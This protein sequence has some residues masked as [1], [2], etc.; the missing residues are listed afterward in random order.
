MRLF[1]N[2]CL[3]LALRRLRV[4]IT[5]SPF[6]LLFFLWN[7]SVYFPL[8]SLC[9]VLCFQTLLGVFDSIYI[10]CLFFSNSPKTLHCIARLGTNFVRWWTL[11]KNDFSCLNVSGV[12]RPCIA[13]VFLTSGFIP[14][15]LTSNPNHSILLF[16]K[17]HSSEVMQRF[18]TSYFSG[19]LKFCSL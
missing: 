19:H 13:Y 12:Y 3:S 7:R 16:V 18:S 5:I 15:W 8:C 9:E 17:W 14:F 2:R 11:H 10:C 6:G 1:P 4:R